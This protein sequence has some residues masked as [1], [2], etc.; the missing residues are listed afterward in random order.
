MQSITNVLKAFSSSIF[1]KLLERSIKVYI[2]KHVGEFLL[3]ELSTD[4]VDIGLDGGSF[5]SLYL[6]AEVNSCGC[7]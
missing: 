3:H 5:A 1:N 6:N 7:K 2:Q 4:Q